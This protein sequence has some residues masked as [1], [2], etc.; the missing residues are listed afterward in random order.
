MLLRGMLVDRGWRMEAKRAR[1]G[2]YLNNHF[3]KLAS[4][5]QSPEH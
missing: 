5:T 4:Q 3:H 2:E 1:G